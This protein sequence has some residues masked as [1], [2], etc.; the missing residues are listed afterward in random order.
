LPNSVQIPGLCRD[1]VFPAENRILN[2]S[3]QQGNGP[4]S[5]KYVDGN[6]VVIGPIGD[7]S[8]RR[9]EHS[10]TSILNFNATFLHF[11]NGDFFAASNQNPPLDAGV[12]DF[13]EIFAPSPS[14][15]M[16]APPPVFE[17]DIPQNNKENLPTI[18]ASNRSLIDFGDDA[19]AQQF[20]DTYDSG[21]GNNNEMDDGDVFVVGSRSPSPKPTSPRVDSDEYES[22]DEER[23]RASQG[24]SRQTAQTQN[25]S[26]PLASCSRPK[27]GGRGGRT[28]GHRGGGRGGW[29]GNST[30]APLQ[31]VSKDRVCLP[32]FLFVR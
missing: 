16:V 21:A 18:Q 28:I 30:P 31:N 14:P 29:S 17:H 9:F 6:W 15:S 24:S 1:A 4:I 27:R 7:L 2:G 19:A 20:F 8:T 25:A 32:S 26:P 11:I 23:P 10:K 22:V 12:D 5:I 13:M 3:G